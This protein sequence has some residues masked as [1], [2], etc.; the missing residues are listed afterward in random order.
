V[1]DL[2]LR[3]RDLDPIETAS[4][5]EFAALPPKRLEQTV[6]H[7][8]DNARHCRA[9]LAAATE[10]GGTG[11]SLA[12][13]PRFSRSAITRSARASAVSSPVASTSSGASG[14]S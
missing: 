1:L 7:V 10:T 8:Y 14:G 2:A 12:I 6:R 3:T 4:R 9:K 11:Y 13:M 5:D